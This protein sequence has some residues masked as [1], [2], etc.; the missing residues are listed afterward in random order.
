MSQGDKNGD[1]VGVSTHAARTI[2]YGELELLL[3]AV[4]AD[5]S[6]D[7]YR[8]AVVEE[9]ALLKGAFTTRKKS[10]RFLRELYLLDVR[11]PLFGALRVLWE[12]N[13]ESRPTLALLAAVSRDDLLRVTAPLILEKPYG[14]PVGSG[15]LAEAV[16]ARFPDRMNSSI[17]DK[18]GRNTASS[19]TQSGHLEGRSKK[20]RS[21]VTLT[22]ETVTYALLLGY[23]S[24]ERGISLYRTLWARLLDASES[25]MD[26]LA[27][28]ANQRGWLEYRRVGEVAEFGFARLLGR[29]GEVVGG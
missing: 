29:E 5:G 15:M 3:D 2:M 25:E 11:E 9:N 24:G 23:L 28:A 8:Q 10:L 13:P 14:S 26:A 19:W 18:V 1:L 17:L 22:V 27:F 12:H 20:V 7:D 16:A 4:P 21:R 6:V